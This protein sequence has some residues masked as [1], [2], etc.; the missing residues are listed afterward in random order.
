M[1]LGSRP[2]HKYKRE[3][4]TGIGSVNSLMTAFLASV[5]AAPFPSVS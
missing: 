3:R 5:P 4:L 1:R 2:P